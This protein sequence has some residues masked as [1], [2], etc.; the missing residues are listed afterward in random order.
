MQVEIYQKSNKSEWDEF[1][2]S[3]KN[4]TFLFKRDYMD[5]HADRFTDYSLIV[6]IENRIVALLPANRENEVV[7]SHQGLTYGGLIVNSAMTTTLYLLVFGELL[8]FLARQNVSSII[9]KTVPGIYHKAPAEED[10]YA[11]F[12]HGARLICR[13]VL[14]VVSASNEMPVQKRRIRGAKSAEK[15]GLIISESRDWSGFWHILGERLKSRHQVSPVHSLDEILH[16]NALFPDNIRLFVALDGG[17]A[18]AG[19]VIFHTAMAAH[20]QYIASSQEGQSKGALDL[21]FHQLIYEEFQDTQ[22]FDFGISNEQK[23]RV[24]NGGLID[25]KE[26]FGARAVVHDHYELDLPSWSA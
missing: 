13:D 8:E 6:R 25:F 20:A 16:L 21:L 14:S 18:L 23:G 15:S 1:V 24:L 22:C 7:H 10:R 12:L 4:G 2:S 3:S 26:G 19:C 17:K 5:Y 9:Y 11:L